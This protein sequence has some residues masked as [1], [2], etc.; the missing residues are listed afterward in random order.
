MNAHLCNNAGFHIKMS[1]ITEVSCSADGQVLVKTS[2]KLGNSASFRVIL[3]FKK[4]HGSA[5]ALLEAFKYGE[6]Y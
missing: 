6:L 1:H 5:W 2:L 4:V 3:L